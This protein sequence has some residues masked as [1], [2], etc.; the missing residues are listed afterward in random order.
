MHRGVNF[1]HISE[2]GGK[3]NILIKKE[4]ANLAQLAL[5]FKVIINSIHI[6]CIFKICLKL[7]RHFALEF[8]FL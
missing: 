6:T 5:V 7:S 3:R 2:T 4:Q 1:Y 8:K